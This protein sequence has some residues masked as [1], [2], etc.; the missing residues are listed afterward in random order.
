MFSSI[1]GVPYEPIKE[2]GKCL[3]INIHNHIRVLLSVFSL[4]NLRVFSA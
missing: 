1:P 2:L 3:L 4:T